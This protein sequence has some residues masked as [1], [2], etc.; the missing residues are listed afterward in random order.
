MQGR[1]F[2]KTMCEKNRSIS[3]DDSNAAIVTFQIN[4]PPK[5]IRYVFGDVR[6]LC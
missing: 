1:I 4:R 5:T 3:Q 6:D 2:K